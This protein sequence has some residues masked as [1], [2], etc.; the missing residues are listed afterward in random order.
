[1]SHLRHLKEAYDVLITDPRMAETMG[2]IEGI[3][4]YSAFDKFIVKLSEI[5]VK[6]IFDAFLAVV[7]QE[8]EFRTKNK[9]GREIMIDATPLK[10]KPSDKDAE[11]NGHYKMKGYAL[12]NVRDLETNIPLEYHVT[13]LCEDE[14]HI[15]APM[16]MRMR[17][18]HGIFPE[19]VFIDCGYASFKNIARL[20]EYWDID[21]ICNLGEDWIRHDDANREGIERQYHK[22][23][24]EAGWWGNI[25]FKFMKLYLMASNDTRRFDLVGQYHRNSILAIYEEAPD[26]YLDHYHSRNRHE[27][28]HGVEKNKT[29]IMNIG[30]KG[31]QKFSAYV[32]LHLIALL[33][34]AL[35]R[36]QNGETEEL[37]TL[38]GLV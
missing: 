19:R 7:R 35:I 11:Y 31:I 24:G 14:A 12:H 26:G 37:V 20:R 25:S 6:P 4:T 27:G 13:S 15:M 30:G 28:Q 33:A 32:G 36:L 22:K 18:I 34:V 17:E 2:F 38:G 29:E 8:Y 3:P 9:L 1:M 23:W 16:I 10:G 21:V 5:G